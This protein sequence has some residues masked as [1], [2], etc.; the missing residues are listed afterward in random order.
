[1]SMAAWYSRNAAAF[2]RPSPPLRVELTTEHRNFRPVSDRRDTPTPLRLPGGKGTPTLIPQPYPPTFKP[3]YPPLFPHTR[4]IF[5]NLTTKTDP[6]PPLADKGQ[7]E[8]IFDIFSSLPFLGKADTP[9]PIKVRYPLRP[10]LGVKGTST[11]SPLW[12][13]MRGYLPSVVFFALRRRPPVPQPSFPVQTGVLSPSHAL[14]C[15]PTRSK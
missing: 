10:H 11:P 13:H 15:P 14:R 8:D 4:S 9:H 12:G 7:L 1:M 3:I 2:T 6:H 5:R